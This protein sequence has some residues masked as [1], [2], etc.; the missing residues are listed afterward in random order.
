MVRILK[1]LFRQQGTYLFLT[2]KV[3]VGYNL[4]SPKQKQSK[5]TKLF[6]WTH[7]AEKISM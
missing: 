5:T 7:R 2:S 1:V 3:S 4:P 6:L